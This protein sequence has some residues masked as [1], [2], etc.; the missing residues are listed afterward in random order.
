MTRPGSTVAGMA[1]FRFTK[2]LGTRDGE[3][4]AAGDEITVSAEDAAR[5]ARAGYGEIVDEPAR[6]PRS[7]GED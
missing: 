6:R 3:N 5:Y 4:H 1:R 2:Q 7:K